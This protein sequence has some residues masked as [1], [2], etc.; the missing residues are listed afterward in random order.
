M[1][2]Q[3]ESAFTRIPGEIRNK[4]YE[5]LFVGKT[6]HVDTAPAH[7]QSHEIE[8]ENGTVG[9]YWDLV[10]PK[11]RGRLCE[12]TPSRH[13][14]FL[15]LIGPARSQIFDTSADGLMP[16][17]LVHPYLF[18]TLDTAVCTGVTCT[19]ATTGLTLQLL[20]TCKKI[21]SEVALMP[22]TSTFF[23]LNDANRPLHHES[24]RRTFGSANRAAILH[25]A[26]HNIGQRLFVNIPELFPQLQRVW[27]D[28]DDYPVR[29]LNRNIAKLSKL[30]G[31]KGVAIRVWTDVGGMHKERVVLRMEK[32]V[33]GDG[34]AMKLLL[35]DS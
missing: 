21:H 9:L 11:L 1:N 25:A 29:G 22:Y 24:L 28:L 19:N 35:S 17:Q 2:P 30:A 18:S 12:E 4:I 10:V 20:R 7:P 16:A 31:L 3:N 33:L 23:I 6:V 14:R 26:F 34:E 5:I 15:N 32:A 27:L 8:T 13:D